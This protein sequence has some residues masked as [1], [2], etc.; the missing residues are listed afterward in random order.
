[1]R[2][3]ILL[4]VAGGLIGLSGC[5]EGVLKEKEVNATEHV[6]KK[7]KTKKVEKPVWVNIVD[8]NTKKI[9]KSFVPKDFGFG[10]DDVKYKA[11]ITE[12]SR[13][14]ARGTD[15]KP[16]Y[17]KRM[18]L[19]K[20]KPD[21]Q[22]IKGSPQTIMDETELTEKMLEA[23][24][25]GGDVEVPLYISDSGYSQEDA[26]HLNEVVVASYTTYFKSNVMGRSK[27]IALSAQAINNMIIGKEDPFSFN[28]SVGPSDE[29]HGYQRAPE[30]VDGKLVDGVGGGICQTSST[31]Y[32]AID[33][34]GVSYIEK[35]H[36]SLHVGYVPKGRDATVSYGGYDFRFKNTTGVPLLLKTYV[37]NGSLT[38]EIRT[39]NEYKAL[40]KR[41]I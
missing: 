10:T 31:L 26:A 4:I 3:A 37:G 29:A 17:D 41:A 25:K 33:Q 13:E 22:I 8:P 1:M 14:L 11:A 20:L 40:I 39:S 34:L 5:S 30:A 15:E 16:G 2:G 28:T 21:G 36:H 32:N 6:E 35:H 23:S 18:M 7:V 19:D 9:I 27:N 24:E 38:V 12:W